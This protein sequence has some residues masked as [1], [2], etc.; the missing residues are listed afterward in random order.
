MDGSVRPRFR[1]P[2]NYPHQMELVCNKA[3]NHEIE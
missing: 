1:Q 3:F 2:F